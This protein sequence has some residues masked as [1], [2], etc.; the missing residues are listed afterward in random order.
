MRCVLA[1]E[2]FDHVADGLIAHVLLLKGAGGCE[3]VGG[4]AAP[5]KGAGLAASMGMSTSRYESRSL[6]AS[7]SFVTVRR[8][9]VS[10]SGM[11]T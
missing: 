1:K 4:A 11:R 6:R 8:P 5:P 3:R 9:S 7:S 2:L 10:T